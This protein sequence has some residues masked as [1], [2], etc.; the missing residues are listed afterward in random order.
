MLLR[1]FDIIKVS[2]KFKLMKTLNYTKKL[3]PTGV[4][5]WVFVLEKE[6]FRKMY[7]SGL[8]NEYLQ[9]LWVYDLV[10]IN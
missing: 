10:I 5:L 7:K 3:C 6:P 2:Y 1:N 9:H 8:K 4:R